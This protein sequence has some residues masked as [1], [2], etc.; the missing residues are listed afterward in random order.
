MN[1][2]TR[3]IMKKFNVTVDVALKIQNQMEVDGLNFSECTKREYVIAMNDAY[4]ITVK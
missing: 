1:Q 4:N 3:D 2:V